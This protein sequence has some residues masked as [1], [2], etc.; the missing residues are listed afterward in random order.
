MS[1]SKGATKLKESSAP[2]EVESADTPEGTLDESPND[3]GT[4]IKIPASREP[5]P[6][7]RE[8]IK[9]R[10]VL[11]SIIIIRVHY[12]CTYTVNSL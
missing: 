2:G 12:T 7:F 6:Q 11:L 1:Q 10:Y 9:K 3:T 8:Q 4:A 5:T